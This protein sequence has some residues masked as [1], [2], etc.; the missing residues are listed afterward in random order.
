[1]LAAF[2]IRN[3]F[4][5]NNWNSKQFGIKHTYT[6]TD[7]RSAFVSTSTKKETLTHTHEKKCEEKK[8]KRISRP[9]KEFEQYVTMT[10][11]TTINSVCVCVPT[12]KGI[13]IFSYYESSD[14]NTIRFWDAFHFKCG[15]DEA[16]MGKGTRANTINVQFK[17]SMPVS[18]AFSIHLKKRRKQQQPKKAY[19]STDER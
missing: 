17:S 7:G 18:S 10:T 1:M 9:K 16:R 4:A 6:C 2:E 12:S 13:Y 14:T 19:E 5:S 15:R 11:T 3:L 8:R